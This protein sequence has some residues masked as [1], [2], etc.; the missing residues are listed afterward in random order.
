MI[1]FEQ[2]VATDSCSDDQFS[3]EFSD[4]GGKSRASS[5]TDPLGLGRSLANT[6]KRRDFRLSKQ[7][8]L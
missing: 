6:Q 7:V 4:E 8:D 1:Q 2:V 3:T 5:S